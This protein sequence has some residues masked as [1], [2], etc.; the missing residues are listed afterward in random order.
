MRKIIT[1]LICI[2]STQLVVKADDDR[3][4]EFKQLPAIS[5]QLINRQFANQ[6][7][8]LVKMERD[9]LD[10]SYDVI[11]T[12][13]DK[14]K[15]NKKGDWT[16]I[17]CQYTQVPIALIPKQIQSYL[18]KNYAGQKVIKLE[19]EMKKQYEIELNNGLDIKFNWNYRVIDI[20]D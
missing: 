13:G 19:R 12:N 6:P 20:D 15:F 10:K 3:P 7:I 17:D 2:L 8:A 18:S 16:E 4:I 1:F 5:Q 14:I 11:F 9:F